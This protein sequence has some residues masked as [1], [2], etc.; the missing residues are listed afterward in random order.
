MHE[1]TDEYLERD[2]K[3]QDRFVITL[4]EGIADNGDENDDDDVS[5]NEESTEDDRDI[6]GGKTMV[7]TRTLT[8]YF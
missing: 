1:H 7:A 2:L 5:S 3:V 6:S 8:E 4:G